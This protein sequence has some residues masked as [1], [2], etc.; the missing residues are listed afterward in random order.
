MTDITKCSGEGCPLSETC[1]RFTAVG[2]PY[3]QS[4][5]VQPPYK[6]DTGCSMFWNTEGKK[7]ER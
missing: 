6:E 5:F 3:Y 7:D 4:Y 1:Y 2:D